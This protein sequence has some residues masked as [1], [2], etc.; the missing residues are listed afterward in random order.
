MQPFELATL[1]LFLASY[2]LPAVRAILR[3][4]SFREAEIVFYKTGKPRLF[5]ILVWVLIGASVVTLIIHFAVE[6]PRVG[7][8]LLY[9]MVLMFALVVPLN[10]VPFLRTRTQKTLNEKSAAD[11][12]ASG[13][14]KIAVAALIVLL[15]F[16]IGR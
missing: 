15:P 10:F 2:L 8:L 11:Y 3:P 6:K 5:E 16:I 13:I 14:R 7:Q 12:R 1:V 9:V 4:V